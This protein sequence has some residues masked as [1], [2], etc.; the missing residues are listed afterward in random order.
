MIV[1]FDDNADEIVEEYTLLETASR[2]RIKLVERFQSQVSSR[3][4]FKHLFDSVVDMVQQTP[5]P[6]VSRSVTGD[7]DPSWIK[8]DE[9]VQVLLVVAQQ[10]KSNVITDVN[11]DEY[12][13]IPTELKQQNAMITSLRIVDVIER[14]SSFITGLASTNSPSVP[15]CLSR[16]VPF[17]EI[18]IQTYIQSINAHIHTVKATYKLCYVVGRVVLDLSQ[19]G[20]CKP[21]EEGD[22][23]EGEDGDMVEGTG[24]GA[25]TG[26]KNVS[27]EI[28]EESQV[29]GL[30]G[31]EEEEQEEQGGEEDDAFSMD[32]DFK[33]EMGEGKEK[34][35]GSG[36]EEEEEEDHDEHVGD[37]DPLDPGAVD[38]K[39]WGDEKKE[40]EKKESD[41]LMDQQT[42]EQEGE[43]EMTGKEDEKKEKKDKEKQKQEEEGQ[44]GDED[45]HKQDGKGEEEEEEGEE[46]EDEEVMGEER[47]EEGEEQPV[48]QD[49]QE[50]SM[51]EG[52]TLDLPEDLNLDDD[53]LEDGQ[54]QE[55]NL[56]D[57]MGMSVDGDEENNEGGEGDEIDRMNEGEGEEVE[58]AP[59]ATGQGEDETEEEAQMGQDADLSA[60]NER[61]QESEVGKGI[62][63]GLEGD[64]D[65][66]K[67]ERKEEEGETEEIEAD[68]RG[69]DG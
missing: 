41:E 60:A 9:V 28:K 22:S 34:E 5:E 62:G 36:D 8:S 49:Q 7:M 10:M 59:A 12:P 54:D 48:G 30:Q 33:G 2:I 52:D 46:L 47:N 31:E 42:Q 25:G 55:E 63:G 38:E 65:R 61:A 13:H 67:E 35:E 44:E 29:E 6:S 15:N 1:G 20:F 23:G 68:A 58:E 43:S 27:Q 53:G 39:F 37:V 19:K 32:E 64:I 21:Q 18:F 51:P 26:E 50:V 3:P 45:E 16:I 14:L 4:E 11:A 69:Q 17:L 40:E 66:Q 57:D 24:M 56:D